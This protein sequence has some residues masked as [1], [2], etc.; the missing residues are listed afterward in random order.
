VRGL[1]WLGV[2]LVLGLLAGPAH[3][4]EI[5]PPPADAS[6]TVVELPARV[7]AIEIHGTKRT[8]RNVILRELG[9]RPGE[10]VSREQWTVGIARLWNTNLFGNVHARVESR[11][12]KNVAVLDLD[13]RWTLNPLIGFSNGGGSTQIR[14]GVGDF[15]TFGRFLEFDTIYE[16]FNQYNGFS[17]QLKEPRLF[18]RRIDLAGAVERLMRPRPGFV[19]R[20]LHARLETNTLL[21]SDRIRIG[22]SVDVFQAQFLPPGPDSPLPPP[23][24][25]ARGVFADVGLRVGRMDQLRN[26]QQGFTLEVRPGV[27]STSGNGPAWA[28]LWL[29]SMAFWA[30]GERWNV[31]ARLQSAVMSDAPLFLHWYLGGLQQVRGFQDNHF[32]TRDYVLANLELRRVLWDSTWFALMPAVFVDVVAA[33]DDVRGQVAGLAVG[34]GVRFLVPAFVRTGLRV[35]VAMP[36]G[37]QGCD[38]AR[39]LGWSL[40]V[41]QFFF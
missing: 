38:T 11:G 21:V 12:G 32:R 15:N 33:K 34:G 16:R 19:D 39:C 29:E 10:T 28:Q 20:R 17:L 40:G 9:V 31:A 26:R 37:A 1:G 30:P 36:I 5:V 22:G 35:D 7:D 14:L 25:T 24:P 23:M 8:H 41:Y 3:A 4:A 13:E 6:T 18:G 27:G 2:L